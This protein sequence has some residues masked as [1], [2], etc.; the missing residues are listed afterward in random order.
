MGRRFVSDPKSERRSLPDSVRFAIA[1]FRAQVPSTRLESRIENAL[2]KADA[3]GLAFEP[4]SESRRPRHLSWAGVLVAA[5]MLAVLVSTLVWRQALPV[6]EVRPSR[7]VAV[8]LSADGS[9]WAELPWHPHA[10]PMGHARVRLDVPV[11][12]ASAEF[13]PTPR[14]TVCETKRCV[15]RFTTTTEGENGPLRLRIPSPGRYEIHVHHVS[16]H[17]NLDEHFVVI[18]TRETPP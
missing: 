7:E 6:L 4:V 11:E 14:T 17:R 12:L 3:E 18:A 10:H 9:G 2:K 13:L 16:R 1:R 8:Q 5:V 15:H